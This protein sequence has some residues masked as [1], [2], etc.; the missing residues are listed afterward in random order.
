MKALEYIKGF[1]EL[2]RKNSRISCF[3]EL[4][5]LYF[6]QILRIITRTQRS[7]QKRGKQKV[8]N[9]ILSLNCLSKIAINLKN[10]FGIKGVL[11]TSFILLTAF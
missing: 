6:Q 1:D 5:D 8:F 4:N 10:V 11:K 9:R 3:I 2:K 7:S